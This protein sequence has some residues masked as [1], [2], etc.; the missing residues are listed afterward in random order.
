MHFTN[1][2]VNEKVNL[3]SK[4]IK[5]IIRNY[6]PHETATCD[7]RDLPW[8]YSDIKELIPKK[9]QAYK[10]YRQNK[11]KNMLSVLTFSI[12]VK[13]SKRKI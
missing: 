10:S 9:N 11:K 4:T 3:F 13:F 12:K 2:N 7:D 8:V 6:I 1:V 5:N